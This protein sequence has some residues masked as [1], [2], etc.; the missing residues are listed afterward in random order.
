MA[1]SFNDCEFA[2]DAYST[3]SETQQFSE[4][5]VGEA[6][7]NGI[8]PD[9]HIAVEMER[10]LNIEHQNTI[11]AYSLMFLELKAKGWSEFRDALN[12]RRLRKFS[13]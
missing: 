8:S 10:I 13:N 3:N 5:L 1:I 7:R 11:K 2:N 12:W 6:M 9:P 4:L